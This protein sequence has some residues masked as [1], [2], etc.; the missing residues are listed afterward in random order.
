MSNTVYAR[1]PSGN[2]IEL[3]TD[4]AG[5]LKIAG[6]ITIGDITLDNVEISNDDG[7]PVPVS[8]PLTDT[9]LRASDVKVT[10]DSE[11][12]VLGA[13]SATIGKLAANSGVDIG[14]VD[15]TSLPAIPAGSN[16]IGSVDVASALPAG[17]NNIGD[18][19]VATL[20]S[21]AAG[22]NSIGAVA[23]NS[24]L[25]SATVT[26]PADTT[27]Y[28]A[29]DV[30]STAVGAVIEFTGM[31]RA[32]GG[33][34]T[35]VKARL[36]T[37]QSTNVASYRL[38]LFHTSPTA[39][40]DN[41]QYAMLDANKD[42]RIGMIDFPAAATE[43]TGSDAAASMRPSSDGSYPPPNLWYKTAGADTKL[44]G[45]LETISAFTPASGQTFFIELGADG[46]S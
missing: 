15:V 38:H 25:S 35:I 11:A 34:G 22:T 36:M 4:A 24:V 41:A 45:I 5:A 29:K 20:P 27:A 2:P 37:N 32:V 23:S 1:D 21:L 33:T 16:K 13:G 8:G 28:A 6:D 44:Y 42:K 40:A 7:N 26:R 39:I 43:G 30:I 9:Q 19:D 14:D 3:Q 31:A 46:L 17:N 10:L 12:V 18:V